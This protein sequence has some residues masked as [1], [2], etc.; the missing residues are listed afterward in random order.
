M[1][2]E[3]SIPTHVGGSSVVFDRPDGEYIE[4]ADQPNAGDGAGED[5]ETIIGLLG[6]A[7]RL[8]DGQ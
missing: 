8:I 7:Q 2:G 6:E 3:S 1:R 4:D 5:T